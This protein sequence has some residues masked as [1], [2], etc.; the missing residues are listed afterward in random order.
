MLRSN[1]VTSCRTQL[2]TQNHET[3]PGLTPALL[4]I[5]IEFDI[6]LAGRLNT[7]ALSNPFV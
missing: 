5:L 4:E 6:T 1:V 2:F 7:V 3:R